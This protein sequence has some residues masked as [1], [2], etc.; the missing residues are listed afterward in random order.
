MYVVETQF[1]KRNKVVPR[2]LCTV[3]GSTLASSDRMRTRAL[4]C[5]CG[6]PSALASDGVYSFTFKP[7]CQL[8]CPYM[9]G[10]AQRFTLVCHGLSSPHNHTINA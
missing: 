1:T 7:N 5:S 3:V 4:L 10:A 2:L 6:A 9:P 8:E